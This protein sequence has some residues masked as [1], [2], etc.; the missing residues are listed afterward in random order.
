[1]VFGLGDPVQQDNQDGTYTYTLSDSSEILDFNHMEVID[2]AITDAAPD[3]NFG[4]STTMEI[5]G[6]CQNVNSICDVIVS[7]DSSQ[8]P[9][10]S[11]VRNLHSLFLS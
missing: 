8:L 9:L 1:M 11:N 2:T 4:T 6:G 7:F 10:D 5:G 3:S